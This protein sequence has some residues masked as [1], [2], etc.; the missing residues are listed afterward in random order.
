M[1]IQ[2]FKRILHT[3]T[4]SQVIKVY[5]S[6]LCMPIYNIYTYNYI[7]ALDVYTITVKDPLLIPSTESMTTSQNTGQ[8]K[9]ILVILTVCTLFSINFHDDHNN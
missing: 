7:G 5:I 4:P 9:Y 3:W 2:V 8:T 1:T 6:L